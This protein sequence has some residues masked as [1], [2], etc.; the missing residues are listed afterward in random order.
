[1]P[2]QG[3]ERGAETWD[4]LLFPKG[5]VQ[6]VRHEISEYHLPC[7]S[8]SIRSTY[9]DSPRIFPKACLCSGDSLTSGVVPRVEMLV[10][11]EN[12]GKRRN[13]L[14]SLGTNNRPDFP[15]FTKTD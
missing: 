2:E 12:T 11:I 4:T 15:C 7:I 10:Q 6:N 8:R 3:T 1:M 5:T 13:P 9:H 14:K